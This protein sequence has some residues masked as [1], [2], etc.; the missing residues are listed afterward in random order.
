MARS[1]V[2]GRSKP[3]RSKTKGITIKEDADVF[4]SEVA[5]L[6]TNGEKGKGK[7]KTL[8]LTDASTDSNGFYRN[9]PN[10]SK[11]EDVGS[12]K[13]DM[14]IAQRAERRIKKLNESSRA[15][16]YQPTTTIPP[17]PKQA[18]VLAPPVQGPPPKSMNQV[19]AKG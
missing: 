7:H 14:L 4:T 3:P 13:K 12:D 9:D 19:K 17:V 5:K 1:K 16:T 18:M 10:Q 11:S 6:S 2:A 8:E 15:R